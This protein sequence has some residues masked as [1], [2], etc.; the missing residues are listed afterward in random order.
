[1]F[2][3]YAKRLVSKGWWLCGKGR[4]A[5]LCEII[6]Q[7]YC[8]SFDNA[9]LSIRVR[10]SQC[11]RPE[12]NWFLYA[13]F[14]CYKFFFH[15]T[16]SRNMYKVLRTQHT[17][18]IYTYKTSC[19]Y[20][21]YYHISYIHIRVRCIRILIYNIG[22]Y[23]IIYCPVLYILKQNCNSTCIILNGSFIVVKIF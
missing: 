10:Y 2:N 20:D 1:M 14:F 7:S 11:N 4:T 18:K 9:I 16:I 6:W 13:I 22:T 23:Y 19:I 21:V 8:V 3:N 15:L 12:R 5:G 17:E